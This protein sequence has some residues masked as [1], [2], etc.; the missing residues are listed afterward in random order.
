MGGSSA[1]PVVGS[2]LTS[3]GRVCFH[4]AGAGPVV[5][6]VHGMLTNKYLWRHQLSGLADIRRCIAIDLLAHGDSDLNKGRDVS[7]IA[8][9]G[10]IVE[11]LDA[12][13]IDRIDIVGHDSGVAISQV[14]A[15]LNPDRVR[16]LTITDCGANDN[17]SPAAF[18]E[19]LEANARGELGETL[20]AMLADKAVYRSPDGLGLAYEDPHGVSDHDIDVYLQPC[21][22]SERR[23]RDLER[24]LDAVDDEYTGTAERASRELQVPALIV[25][26]TD[27][28]YFPMSSAYRIADTI[29]SAKRPVVILGGRLFFPVE[30]PD[31]FNDVLRAHLLADCQSDSH[32]PSSR[33]R[34]DD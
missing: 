30:R 32:G 29:A 7:L 28:I 14:F 23:L 16:T 12:L 15:A 10:M 22:R 19:L 8:N 2:V 20:H 6:F 4:E 9:V 33:M 3:S 17:S 31:T 24:F 18:A 21:I 13:Q 5:L 34:P 1:A 25:W 11:V 26:G 27:D